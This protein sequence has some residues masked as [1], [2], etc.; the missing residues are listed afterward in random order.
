MGRSARGFRLITRASAR[1]Q[2]LLKRSRMKKLTMVLAVLGICALS[3]S[4]FASDCMMLDY[5]DGSGSYDL[6][7]KWG[8][9][10]KLG[11]SPLYVCVGEA[12]SPY[13][14]E[15]TF[16]FYDTTYDEEYIDGRIVEFNAP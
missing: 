6:T 13:D 3:E 5:N 12:G 8:T 14:G 15:W 9:K 1:A 7:L 11:T 10:K 16:D 4:A 2:R